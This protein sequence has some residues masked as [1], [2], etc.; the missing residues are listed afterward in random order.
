MTGTYKPLRDG[1]LLRID[2]EEDKR[3]EIYLPDRMDAGYDRRFRVCTVV[4]A[5]P[6]SECHDRTHW[7]SPWR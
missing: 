3:G 2:K 1:L 5:G 6:Q 7:P 4:A